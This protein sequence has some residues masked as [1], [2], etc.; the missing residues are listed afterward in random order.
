M[1]DIWLIFT[2][3]LLLANYLIKIQLLEMLV[4][5]QQQWPH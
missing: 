1:S 2:E 5:T 3:L 4:A